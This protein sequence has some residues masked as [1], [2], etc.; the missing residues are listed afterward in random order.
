MPNMSL[1]KITFQ[2]HV[3]LSENN[4]LL[5]LASFP[6]SQPSSV[7]YNESN[8]FPFNILNILFVLTLSLVDDLMLSMLILKGDGR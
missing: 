7:N 8:T 1:Q 6:N 2:D 3:S 4:N 5:R